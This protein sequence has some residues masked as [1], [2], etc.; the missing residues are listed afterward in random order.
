MGDEGERFEWSIH[1]NL[2]GKRPQSYTNN[3]RHLRN[4]KSRG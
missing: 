2:I 3:E 4:A 1:V